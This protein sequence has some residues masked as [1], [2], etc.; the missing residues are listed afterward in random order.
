MLASEFPLAASIARTIM[1]AVVKQLANHRAIGAAI[2]LTITAAPAVLAASAVPCSLGA[3]SR[4]QS[5]LLDPLASGRADS[6]RHPQSDSLRLTLAEARARALGANPELLAS[7]L[8]TAV[9]RG[10]LRQAGIIP[11]NPSFEVLGPGAGNAT[12]PAVAQELEVFGQRGVRLS[13][14]RYG[15]ERAAAGV[16]NA[17]R[18]TIGDVDRAFYRLVSAARRAQLADEVLALNQRLSAVTQRQ[19]TEGEISRLDFNLATVEV[20]R[21]RSRA[22]AAHR[23]RAEQEIELARILGLPRGT[24]IAPVLDASEHAPVAA[25]ALVDTS[26]SMQS[27]ILANPTDTIRLSDRA[28]S[29]DVDSLTVLA[30]AHRPDLTAQTAAVREASARVALSRREAFPNL[31]IRGVWQRAVDEKNG[32]LSPGIG[33]TLPL[34]NRNQGQTQALRA[35]AAQADLIRAALTTRVRAEV[36]SAVGAYRSAAQEVEVLESTVL[37][38]ARQ[39][40][41]L[42]EVAYRE[43]KVGLPVLILIRN[44]VSDAELEYWTAW[45]AE[46]EALTQLTEVTGVAGQDLAPRN[47]TSQSNQLPTK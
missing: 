13:A 2:V 41:Q 5:A 17:T 29:L 20:G 30:L 32:R 1:A 14:A 12:Q 23:E 40:R 11:F 38:P 3:Q 31:V 43:G 44:Q 47:Q 39:N 6:R 22:L 7:R 37:A 10:D 36:A 4:L 21:S 45:L 42:L 9:A 27:G 15:Y 34:L 8:D 26:R 25:A 28:R 24:P 16:A 19:L 33:I 18:L 46:R 35:Q